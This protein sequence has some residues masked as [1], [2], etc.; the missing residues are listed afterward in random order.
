[1][2]DIPITMSRCK[3]NFSNEDSRFALYNK[4]AMYLNIFILTNCC[5]KVISF[6][7]IS[8]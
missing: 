7:P 1:M 3:E 8:V 6:K 5:G 2:C 4:T